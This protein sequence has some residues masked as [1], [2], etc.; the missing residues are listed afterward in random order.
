QPFAGELATPHPDHVKAHEHGILAVREAIGNDIV[1]DSAD[2]ANHDLGPDPGELVHGGQSADIDEVPDLAMSTK[3]RGGRENR[4]VADEAVVA[5]MAV[6]H[7]EAV[8]ADPRQSTALERGDVHRH[9]PAQHTHT[10][11]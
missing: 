7:E 8:I 6:V 5:D 3:R 10:L 9:A 1:A 2:T 4:V 11:C